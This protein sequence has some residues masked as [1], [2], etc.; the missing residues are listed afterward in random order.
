MG[1]LR[2]TFEIDA[3]HRLSRHDYECQNLHGHR[4]RF[5]IEVEGPA[6]PQTGMIVDFANVKDPI[7][8]AFDHNFILNSDDPILTAKDQLEAEQ[9]KEFYLINGEPTAEN[10]ADEALRLIEDRLSD[11]EKSRIDRIRVQ[12]HETPTSSVRTERSIAND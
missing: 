8:A 2:K 9:E 6:D 11:A 5:E 12:L 7:V 4:Y 3:G 1:V 10:I